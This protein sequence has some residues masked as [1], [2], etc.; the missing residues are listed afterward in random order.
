MARNEPLLDAE[1]TSVVSDA[2]IVA[3]SLAAPGRPLDTRLMLH[4]LMTMDAR[5]TA[6]ERICRDYADAATVL[7]TAADDPDPASGGTWNLVQLTATATVALHTAVRI[8]D[9]YNLWPLPPGVLALGLVANSRSAAAR[10][11][12]V[13][14][15]ADHRD[16]IA[17]IQE[18]L[19]G[20]TSRTC[21]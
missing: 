9:Q 7:G 11:L 17:V 20:Q 18:D 4:A 14:G 5:N 12:R 10:A 2:L 8:A 16:L 13:R 19:L 3:A 1:L 6:W 15:G 21:N